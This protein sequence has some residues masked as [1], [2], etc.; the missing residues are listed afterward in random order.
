VEFDGDAETQMVLVATHDLGK[1]EGVSFRLV[2]RNDDYNWNASYRLSGR[3]GTEMFLIVGDPN[4][5]TFTNRLA[6]KI[7]TPMTLGF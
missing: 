4:S 5:R 2:R 7:V 1:Y 3:R 6:F